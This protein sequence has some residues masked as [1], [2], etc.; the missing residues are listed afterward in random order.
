MQ[1]KE[2][3]LDTPVEAEGE[4]LHVLEESVV[5][6]GHSSPPTPDDDEDMPSPTSRL[7][8]MP[9][10]GTIDSHDI[11]PEVSWSPAARWKSVI[12]SPPSVTAE[13]ESV[14][15]L[16]VSVVEVGHRSP[17]G[18]DPD[19]N[20]ASALD[21][22][23][24]EVGHSSP[25]SA[26]AK[27][28]STSVLDQSAVAVGPVLEKVNSVITLDPP[29]ERLQSLDNLMTY[30]T[31]DDD[32][33][34][35]P[36]PTSRLKNLPS[37]G[38]IETH[39]AASTTSEASVRTLLTSGQVDMEAS[40]DKV[41]AMDGAST[42]PVQTDPVSRST[43]VP[44]VDTRALRSGQ[45]GG[46]GQVN[47][48]VFIDLSNSPEMEPKPVESPDADMWA[49]AARKPSPSLLPR[50]ISPRASDQLSPT[51]GLRDLPDHGTFENLSS[52]RCSDEVA[53][54]LPPP[55]ILAQPS[56]LHDDLRALMTKE[57]SNVVQEDTS[58]W[59][60]IDVAAF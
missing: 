38:T 18:T 13:S 20:L 30:A 12:S 49:A 3:R 14:H 19:R 11:S 21:E 42:P 44:Q 50:H 40:N 16:E 45:E 31:T 8:K 47:P 4:T 32:D 57:L 39:T 48:I 59:Q 51:V 52:Q 60:P 22:S 55:L 17:P 34:D 6:V 43:P 10:H 54:G 41:L 27:G 23:V 25:P 46:K 26:E 7:K 35:M 15:A 1:N 53:T 24:V 9:S 58:L 37:H 29:M 56:S 36:S 28:L 5:E 33:D 2:E